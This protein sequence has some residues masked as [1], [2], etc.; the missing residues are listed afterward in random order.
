MEWAAGLPRVRLA[1]SERSETH[2]AGKRAAGLL[3][4]D[5]RL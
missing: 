4:F 5:R 3:T 1:L 2:P